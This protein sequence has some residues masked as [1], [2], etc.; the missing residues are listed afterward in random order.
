M[1][2]RRPGETPLP[3]ESHARL[4]HVMARN[5]AVVSCST[6]VKKTFWLP[7]SRNDGDD[8]IKWEQ[9]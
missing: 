2:P 1:A 3:G 6:L 4:C 5:A 9:A 8:G 7:D